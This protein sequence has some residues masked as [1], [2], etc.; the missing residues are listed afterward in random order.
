[1]TQK[2]RKKGKFSLKDEEF[3]FNNVADLS[4]QE[5]ADALNRTEE[6]VKNFV[7]KHNLAAKNTSEDEKHRLRLLEKLKNSPYYTWIVK[8]LD[9]DEVKYFTESWISFM[10]QLNEDVL[11]T[12]ELDIKEMIKLDIMLS[13]CSKNR[14]NVEELYYKTELDL[15]KE[16]SLDKDS[17]DQDMIARLEVRLNG[18]QKALDDYTKETAT[19]LQEVDKIS[20]RLKTNRNERVKKI[21]TAN[22]SWAG[23]L[24]ALEDDKFRLNEGREMELMRLAKD[25]AKQELSQYHT[26][27]DG[28]VEQPFLTPDTVMEE[29][30]GDSPL[31]P[32]DEAA[33]K[34]DN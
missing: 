21:E 34:V 12:E 17:R 25:K 5:M 28:E 7:D 29:D 9:E 6:T 19:L 8:Q 26:Y 32:L 33:E 16:L 13:R 15:D 18:C 23:Y 10:Q 20:K 22:S 14:K 31:E 4:I 30:Q 11:W 3:I 27:I 2:T 24:R 1:M